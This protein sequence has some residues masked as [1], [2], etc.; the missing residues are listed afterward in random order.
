MTWSLQNGSLNLSTLR[1]RYHEGTLHPIERIARR[2][3]PH[4][5]AL[6]ALVETLQDLPR[7]TESAT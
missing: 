6:A 7:F 5:Q 2:T 1:Q 4:I 3:G